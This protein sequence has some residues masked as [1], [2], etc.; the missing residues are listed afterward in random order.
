VIVVEPVPVV[1]IEVNPSFRQ[2]LASIV[3]RHFATDIEFIAVYGT[4][5][6]PDAASTLRPRAILLGMGSQGLID[7]AMLRQIQHIWPAT[8]V[9]AMGLLDD[10]AYRK[11]ALALGVSAFIAKEQLA[12][13][14]APTVQR[15]VAANKVM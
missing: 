10:E 2:A 12:Q 4:W 14:L 7:P 9:I 11:A 13:E 6:P 3:T 5:P 1:F 8:P 15:V